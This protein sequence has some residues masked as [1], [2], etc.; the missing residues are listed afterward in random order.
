MDLVFLFVLIL[1]GIGAWKLV[2]NLIGGEFAL[3]FFLLWLM[4]TAAAWWWTRHQPLLLRVPVGFLLYLGLAAMLLP[5]SWWSQSR[6]AV[7]AEAAVTVVLVRYVG[8][9]LTRLIE[10]KVRV[11]PS[12]YLDQR[13]N[14]VED[15]ARWVFVAGIA[16]FVVGVLPLL[17]VFLLPVEW[18]TWAALAWACVA[19]A[20]YL[21]KFRPSRMRVLK[22]PLG[23]WMFV[24]A[25]VLLK[26]FQPQLI[27]PLEAGS[28]AEI[29]YLV[30][31]ST[32]AALFAEIVVL[33]TP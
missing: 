14:L 2:E 20:W 32:A 16:W 7:A 3:A 30:Y 25:V 33:G 19:L 5:L 21:Y 11:A 18:I 8:A 10:P 4:A 6:L 13:I 12:W 24:A 28:I 31:A 9:W 22:L 27:G 26:L 23:L 15:L 17:L 1:L 29:G